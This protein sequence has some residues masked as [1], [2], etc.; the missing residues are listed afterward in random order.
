M[1]ISSAVSTPSIATKLRVAS[2]PTPS[3]KRT[4]SRLAPGTRNFIRQMAENLR[5]HDPE[6]PKGRLKTQA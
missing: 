3:T 5:I 6:A 2:A 4:S 1:S